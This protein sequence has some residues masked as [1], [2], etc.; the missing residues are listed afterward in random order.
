MSEAALASNAVGVNL[1]QDDAKR[2]FDLMTN[3]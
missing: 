2:M 3:F 1:T